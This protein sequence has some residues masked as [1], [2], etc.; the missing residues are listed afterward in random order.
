MGFKAHL[1][2]GK[3]LDKWLWE[4]DIVMLG[5]NRV[6]SQRTGEPLLDSERGLLPQQ[7]FQ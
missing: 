6:T 1:S 7:Y 2:G 4:R 5:I 3:L